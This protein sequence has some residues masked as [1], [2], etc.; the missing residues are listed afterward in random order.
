MLPA[1]HYLTPEAVQHALCLADLTEFVYPGHAVGL[2]VEQL[3]GGLA[4]RDWPLAV[5]HRGHRVVPPEHNHGQ[6]GLGLHDHSER[7]EQTLW[8]NDLLVL[9]SH[10]RG[11]AC[12]AMQAAAHARKPG[13]VLAVAVPGLIFR[14][15]PRDRWHCAAGHHMDLWLLGEP[16]LSNR[17]A[18]L[19]LAGDVLGLAL[20][21]RAWAHQDCPQPFTEG[22]LVA[23]VM[24]RDCALPVLEAGCLARN[25]L[26]RLD[27]DPALHGGLALGVNLDR[28]V[29][30]RKGIPDIRLLRE[31]APAIVEQMHDLQPWK[32]VSRPAAT[33]REL[34]V[35][36]VPGQSLGALT[37]KVVAAAGNQ[38]DCIEQ[39]MLRG[40]W[41]LCELP[42]AVAEELG[43]YPGQEN[44]V[45]RI[46]L[47][48]CVGHL[49]AGQAEALFAT[50]EH[51][52]HEGTLGGGYR[53]GRRG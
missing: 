46:T 18:L 16:E 21:G 7:A 48:R 12:S 20:P 13:E 32:P 5:V 4:E 29:M 2:L 17:R 43:M 25:L 9:R 52:L 27:L 11:G 14:Q 26:Q 49:Q 44:V 51:A 36:M 1:K 6:L 28:L 40:R 23:S 15:G 19:R 50:I 47:R 3:L 39:V 41:P 33:V 22:G 53:I 35:A 31:Q 8:V 24:S 34:S 42:S 45:L 37:A 38:A 10:T 30:L